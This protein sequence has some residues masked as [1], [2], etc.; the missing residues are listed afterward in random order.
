MQMTKNPYAIPAQV[1]A[2]QE[3]C[4]LIMGDKR[5]LPGE[6]LDGMRRR[7]AKALAKPEARPGD[8]EEP[9]F[10]ALHFAF[11]GG[12]ISAN[13]GAEA[14]KPNVSTINCTVSRTI[15]DSMDGI[16]IAAREAGLTLKAGCGIGYDFSTLRPRGAP[17]KGAGAETSGPLPFMDIFDSICKTVQSAG[18]RRGAQMG[19]LEVGHPDVETFIAAKREDGRLRAFNLSLLVTRSFVQAVKDGAEWPLSFPAFPAEMASGCEVVWRFWPHRDDRYTYNDRGE[20]ACRVYRKV[21]ARELWD[22]VMTSTYNHWDPGFLLIDEI[23]DKNP[24]WFAENIRATNPCGEQPLPPFGACLLGSVNLASMV[25]NPFKSDASFDWDL[26]KR[27]VNVFSRMLDNVVEINGLPLPQQREEIMSKRRHGMGYLGL[28]SAMTMM[29]MQYGNAQSVQFTSD[30]TKGLA[31]ESWSAALDLA[32][33]KGCAPI[34]SQ[35]FEVTPEMIVRDPHLTTIGLKAG[36]KAKGA[37][38]HAHSPYMRKFASVNPALVEELSKVGARYTHAT[39][40]APTGTMAAG[41]GNNASNGIE[42]SFCHAYNRNMIVAGKSTKVSI[43]ML[44]YE[45]LA[46]R[47]FEDANVDPFNPPA[48]FDGTTAA[49]EPK[50]HIDVQAAAQEWIDSAISKTINCPMEMPYEEFK[51]IYIYAVDKGLK[52]CTTYRPLPDRA[53]VLVTNADLA[54]TIYEFQ[55]EDGTVIKARGDELVEYKGDIATAA[56][57]HDALKQGTYGKY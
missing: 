44:S 13:A 25:T 26:Y 34:L 19:C 30:V 45:M 2:L 41:E 1:L 50:A 56:N 8:W 20:V 7:L 57:L 37:L 21:Q 15:D 38:L 49:A 14:F 17:V 22:L 10:W 42:P 11:P 33:E 5:L 52:G 12:R 23:N 39:S 54:K 24:L 40:L 36:D 29:G 32:K 47:Q 9:F 31:L 53:G 16:L 6:T 28:G 4:A 18:G 27:V 3:S 46:Y 51:D 48:L 43:P 55:L 35:E